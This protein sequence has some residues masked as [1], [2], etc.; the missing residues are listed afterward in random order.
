MSKEIDFAYSEDVSSLRDL[1]RDIDFTEATAQKF[2]ESL[3]AESTLSLTI[4]KDQ[5][6]EANK[7]FNLI[8]K[9]RD[10]QYQLEERIPEVRDSNDS[11]EEIAE[12]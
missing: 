1:N 12:K 9:I 11:S 10:L 4:P 6:Q 2:L 3:Y 7:L 8:I 5:L